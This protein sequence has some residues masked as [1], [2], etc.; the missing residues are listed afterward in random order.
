DKRGLLQKFP[1]AA[2][3]AHTPTNGWPNVF[4][5]LA[6]ATAIIPGYLLLNTNSLVLQLIGVCFAS[7]SLTTVG[8]LALL[9]IPDWYIPVLMGENHRYCKVFDFTRFRFGSEYQLPHSGTH[10]DLVSTM[11]KLIDEADAS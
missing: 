8:D 11:E 7:A 5:T 3:L 4:I 6:P 2:A 10:Q 9:F 1:K